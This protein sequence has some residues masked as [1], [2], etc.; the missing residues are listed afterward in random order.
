VLEDDLSV[1]ALLHQY[2]ALAF[3][4]YATAAPYV[5]IDV[6]PKVPIVKSSVLSYCF[7][8]SVPF[9]TVPVLVKDTNFKDLGRYRTFLSLLETV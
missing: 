1:T 2:G 6:N 8:R 7:N 5:N 9:N 4:D 3:W